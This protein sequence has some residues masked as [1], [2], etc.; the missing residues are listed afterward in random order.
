MKESNLE[1]NVV[2]DLY[3]KTSIISTSFRHLWIIKLISLL[4]TFLKLTDF[5]LDYYNGILAFN[6]SNL[7]DAERS[8][9]WAMLINVIVTPPVAALMY[10]LGVSNVVKSNF[11][12]EIS[13]RSN[14]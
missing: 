6:G 12:K 4:T 13:K 2:A 8:L 1:K 11:E 3:E 7:S 9:Y 14:S 5:C 10:R